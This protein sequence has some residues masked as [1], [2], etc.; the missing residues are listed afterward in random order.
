MNL[1]SL[2]YGPLAAQQNLKIKIGSTSSSRLLLHLP[3]AGIHFTCL[4]FPGSGVGLC[5]GDEWEWA[6]LGVGGL[7][8]PY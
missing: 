6:G 1:G 2:C 5:A 8:K 3:G 7:D 4:S